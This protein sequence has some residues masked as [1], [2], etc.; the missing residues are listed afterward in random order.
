MILSK[1]SF[2][3]SVAMAVSAA[4]PNAAFAGASI[5]RLYA[6]PAPNGNGEIPNGTLPTA[7]LVVDPAGSGALFGTAS[8]GG[9][10]E[11]NGYGGGVVL[12]LTPPAK[13]HTVWTESVL[14]AFTGNDDG[15]F[16]ASTANVLVS[17]GDIYGTTVGDAEFDGF[18]CGANRNISCD[19]VYKLTPPA[20]GHTKWTYT[21]LYRFDANS[22]GIEPQ[23]G[24][25]AGPGG[26]LY[27]STAAGAKNGCQNSFT[28]LYATNGC[29]AIFK[30]SPPV[31][32]GDDWTITVLHAFTG[33]TDGGI[34]FG[35]LLA[36]PGGSGDLYGTASTGGSSDC[37]AGAANC[38]VVFKLTPPAAGKT[39][40][41]ETVLY[42]FKDGSD[43][44]APEGALAIRDGVLYGTTNAGG[45]ACEL[46][47][48]CGTVYSLTPPASGHTVWTFKALHAFKGGTDGNGPQAGLAI[49]SKGVLYGT[50]Y[51][52]GDSNTN[53][54]CGAAEGCG[55]AFSLTPP[56]SG[57]TVWTEAVLYHFN[58]GT[59]GG[60]LSGSLAL[61]GNTLYGTAALGGVTACQN[62]FPANCG[63][64]IFKI[65]P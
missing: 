32:T 5:S 54:F 57:H 46:A 33:G 4:S 40:W 26:S 43:G 1:Q 11:V 30:L 19:T 60:Q 63:G 8:R 65:V 52:Q 6:F 56:A 48:G 45:N 51:Q 23:G 16:P 59:E 15:I 47:V 53:I 64:T 39:A 27:G 9:N 7:G 20:A 12:K 55:T 3:A 31:K 13:G 36:D 17:G 38:G 10:Y 61:S 44:F 34:P 25:I 42:S 28:N 18:Y 22:V 50:T 2:M 21:L 62:Q 58:G 14:H 41:T 37:A 49:S 24:L 29:G 35:A